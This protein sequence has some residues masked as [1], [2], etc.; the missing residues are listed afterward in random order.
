MSEI[1]VVLVDEQNNEVGTMEKLEAHEKWVLHRAFSIFLFNEV[2]ELLIQRRDAWK[3]HCGGLWTNTVCSHQ[4]PGEGNLHAAVRRLEEELGITSGVSNLQELGSITYK[5]H[6]DNGLTEHEY[7]FII[8]GNYDG[9]VF[10][11]PEEVMDYKW[12]KIDEVRN[13]VIENPDMYTPWFK[14]IIQSKKYF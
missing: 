2:W 11:N 9:S 6:F 13:D 12:V 8:K 4:L 10:P 14:A 3:Y 7:D 1:L 5:A